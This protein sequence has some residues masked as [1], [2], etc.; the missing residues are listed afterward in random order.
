[1]YTILYILCKCIEI[2]I[3]PD[4][5]IHALFPTGNIEVLFRIRSRY[6]G[7]GP[8]VLA[9]VQVFWIRSG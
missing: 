3:L 9:P 7:S 6:S 4:C 1:M 8:G 5:V 2:C